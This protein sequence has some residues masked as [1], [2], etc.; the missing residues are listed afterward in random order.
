MKIRRIQYF[1]ENKEE[2]SAPSM[3]SE[4]QRTPAEPSGPGVPDGLLL[5]AIQERLNNQLRPASNNTFNNLN[6]LN[7]NTIS[8]DATSRLFQ[9]I[10]LGLPL[11]PTLPNPLDLACLPG[12]SMSHPLW[13]HN[14]CAW[15]GC[16]QPCESLPLFIAHL[17]QAHTFDERSTT[18]MR[19]QVELVDTLEHRLNKERNRL[20]AMMQHLHMKQSPDTTTPTLG[21][22]VFCSMY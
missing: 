13:Q 14:L 6:S 16:N 5:L 11:L 4:A 10:L 19:S 17:S 15:P 12:T 3:L 8:N 22:V 9:S 1:L 18:D 20:Q 2:S 21:K 7:L